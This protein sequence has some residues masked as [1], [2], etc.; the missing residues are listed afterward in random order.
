MTLFLSKMNPH[1][2]RALTP[3]NRRDGSFKRL[4]RCRSPPSQAFRSERWLPE[5]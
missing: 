3:T 2:F 5:R 1:A 4:P